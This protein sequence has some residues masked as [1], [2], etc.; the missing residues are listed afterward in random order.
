MIITSAE[1]MDYYR[2]LFR[3]IIYNYY[4]DEFSRVINCGIT[5]N[6]QFNEVTGRYIVIRDYV[7]VYRYNITHEID[8]DQIRVMKYELITD[9]NINPKMEEIPFEDIEIK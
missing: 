6:S 1:K 2:R 3:D 8:Y 5:F 9:R 7:N 4:E